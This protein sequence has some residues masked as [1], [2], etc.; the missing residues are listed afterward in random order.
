MGVSAHTHTPPGAA[1]PATPAAA[2]ALP[3]RGAPGCDPARVRELLQ[4]HHPGCA[5]PAH[6][7][8]VSTLRAS[9]P[10]QHHQLGLW[11]WER[12]SMAGTAIT[13]YNGYGAGCFLLP[14]G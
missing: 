3:R 12:G 10:E 14:P 11:A 5:T 7:A 8:S 4:Q 6:A 2:A 13:P 9:A 1:R